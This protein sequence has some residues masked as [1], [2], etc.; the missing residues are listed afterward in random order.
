[1]NRL[2]LSKSDIV[3]FKTKFTKKSF[4][5]CWDWEA[6]ID[7]RGY[8][9]FFANG[10]GA[11]AHRIAY[12]LYHKVDPFPKLVCHHCDNKKCV[13][14]HH[15]FLGTYQDNKDDCVKKGRQASGDR[16]G[17]RL[18]PECLKRGNDHWTRKHPEK[19]PR[20][21]K[22]FLH[23]HPE[24][25]ARGIN[26]GR[27]THPE[28]T[29]RGERNGSTKLTSQQVIEIREQYSSNKFTCQQLAKIYKVSGSLI[30]A[31]TKRKIWV[32]I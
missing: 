14:P 1:M 8:G 12:L 27:Y 17:V 22:H 4:R 28:T 6:G 2:L 13:N 18:H 3:R 5:K 29:A 26:S 24:F 19:V 7:N 31:I 9:K 16:N 11:I 30:S 20:G 32:H 23:T 21:N 10:K 15:L 25:A